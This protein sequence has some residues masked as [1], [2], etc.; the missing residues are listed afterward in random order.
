MVLLKQTVRLRIHLS[1][2]L[3]LG[4]IKT[5]FDIVLLNKIKK[6]KINENTF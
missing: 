6:R 2:L 1:C 5:K 4:F 3:I